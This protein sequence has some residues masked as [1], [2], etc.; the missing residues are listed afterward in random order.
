MN[1][2]AANSNSLQ[3]VIKAAEQAGA[4]GLPPV[5]L[6]EPDYCGD[7]GL[8]IGR[9]GQWYYANSPIGRKR[10]VRLFSTILRHDDDG[11][12]YL[13]TPVE[14]IRIEVEDAPFVAIL[15]HREG[16]GREQCLKFETNVGD[17][18]EAGAAHL[19]RMEIDETTQEPS[20]YVHI[21]ARLEALIARSVFYDL[22]EI[23][24]IVG[25]DFGVWS[26]GVFFPLAPAS[27]LGA[28]NG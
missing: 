24:E 16:A 15:M 7:I 1:N 27:M 20:P 14:K 25:D 9:D 5:H 13:V 19:L 2:E 11:E 21:R 23:G 17:I 4:K 8:R 10:L 12:H 18:I 22:M 28:Q 6:W 3:D 26:A